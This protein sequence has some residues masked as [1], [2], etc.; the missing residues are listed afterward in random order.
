MKIAAATENGEIFQHFGATPEFTV[1][2]TDGARIIA[3][4]V[5]ETNGTGHGALIGVLG[6]L[7]ADVVICGGIGGGAKEAVLSA[8]M[9][10]FA[11]ISGRADEAAAAYLAGTLPQRESV[12]T[13]HHHDGESHTCN[14]HHT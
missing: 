14:H 6:G 8:G 9:Q 2:E 7:E 13:H 4:Q 11:G 5:V 1:F 10:L 12:C 3:K